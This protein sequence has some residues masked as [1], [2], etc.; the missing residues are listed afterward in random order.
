MEESVESKGCI[1]LSQGRERLS[2][3]T[4]ASSSPEGEA[5]GFYWV[6]GRP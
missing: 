1:L 2:A 6:R 3:E 5:L 4:G